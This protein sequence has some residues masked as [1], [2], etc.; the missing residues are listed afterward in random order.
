MCQKLWKLAGSRH[1]A[2]F[3]GPPCTSIGLLIMNATIVY[4]IQNK[5]YMYLFRMYMTTSFGKQEFAQ[6]C[7]KKTLNTSTMPH[8]RKLYICLQCRLLSVHRV[9]Y[10]CLSDSFNRTVSWYSQISVDADVS[11][12]QHLQTMTMEHWDKV[13]DDV[14]EAAGVSVGMHPQ[15]RCLAE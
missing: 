6:Y 13:A 7:W 11:F 10:Q 15:D 3:F 2:Y 8:N 5:L 14:A 1:L 12:H 4:G 9:W